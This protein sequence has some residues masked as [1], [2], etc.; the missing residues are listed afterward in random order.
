MVKLLMPS[1]CACG[2]GGWADTILKTASAGSMIFMAI[3]SSSNI[4]SNNIVT[5]NED[6]VHIE[7][8]SYNIIKYNE[9]KKNKKYGIYLEEAYSNNILSNNFILNRIQSYYENCKN[10][11]WHHNFWNR[12]RLLPYLII[13]KNNSRLDFNIDWNPA[14]EPFDIPS[15]EAN[16]E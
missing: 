7:Y 3:W 15:S 16:I 5:N 10:N 12:A 11:T 4:I 13:G 2:S 9:I 1:F 8:S 6:G 14:K